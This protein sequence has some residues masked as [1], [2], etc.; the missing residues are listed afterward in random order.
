LALLLKFDF[1]ALSW[2]GKEIKMYNVGPEHTHTA[3]GKGYC[4][5]C[6]E[7]VK[8]QWNGHYGIYDCPECLSELENYSE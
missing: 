6:N 3:S 2:F 7:V 4:H 8:P 1:E 5:E